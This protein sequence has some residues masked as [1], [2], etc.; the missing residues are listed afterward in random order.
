M[1]RIKNNRCAGL[2]RHQRQT[3]KI[4]HKRIVAKRGS[5]L[6][7][8]YIQITRAGDFFDNVFHIPRGKEL[9]FFDIDHPPCF[10]S[11]N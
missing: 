6:G 4:R 1:G 2:L 3:A 7:H 10:G 9:P 5:A 8:H 11:G